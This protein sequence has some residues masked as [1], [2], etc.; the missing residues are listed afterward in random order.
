MIVFFYSTGEEGV[1]W[2]RDPPHALAKNT[3]LYLAICRWSCGETRG[4]RRRGHQLLGHLAPPVLMV[5]DICRLVKVRWQTVRLLASLPASGCSL[6]VARTGGWCPVCCSVGFHGL[7]AAAVPPP[8]WPG[9]APVG[10]LRGCV[11]SKESNSL[12]F[13]VLLV[14]DIERYL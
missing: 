7:F 6:L 12:T 9:S 3:P 4:T 13:S 1:R 8:L 14:R 2:C 11:K 10:T 5:V